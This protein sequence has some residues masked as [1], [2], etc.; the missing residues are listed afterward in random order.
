MGYIM[1]LEDWSDETLEH[2][3]RNRRE[4]RQK[5]LCDYCQRLA[6]H[7]ACSMPKRH[8]QAAEVYEKIKCK[9]CGTPDPE[10]KHFVSSGNLMHAGWICE[11]LKDL[12]GNES[13]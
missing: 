13:K 2:E 12:F 11:S 3:L 1:Q 7:P 10:R 6:Y 8:Q 9:N 4:S 5:G